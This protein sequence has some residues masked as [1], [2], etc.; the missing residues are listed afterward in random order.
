[1]LDRVAIITLN[2]IVIVISKVF[3]WDREKRKTDA[4]KKTHDWFTGFATR[5]FFLWLE[6]GIHIG[7]EKGRKGVCVFIKKKKRGVIYVEKKKVF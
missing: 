7:H 5:I 6:L 2:K 4:Q 3:Q 1:M